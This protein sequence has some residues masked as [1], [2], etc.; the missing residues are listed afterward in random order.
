DRTEVL[1]DLLNRFL[2]RFVVGYV[3][4][5]DRNARLGLEGLSSRIVS[6]VARGDPIAAIF[7]SNRNR[8]TNAARASGDEGDP[9]HNVFSLDFYMVWLVE[10][11]A[12]PRLCDAAA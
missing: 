4:L 7:Q 11:S 1:G 2:R 9:C 3:E 8:V 5:V 12:Q 6:C 10:W